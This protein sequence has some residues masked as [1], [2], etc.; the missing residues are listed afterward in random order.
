MLEPEG[1]SV[2]V[3][4]ADRHVFV[5]VP[6]RNPAYHV[7][8]DRTGEE[9]AVSPSDFDGVVEAF[10]Q[11]LDAF[12]KGD[13]RPVTELFSQR[14]DV[15][16][17]NP[18]GPPRLGRAEVEKATEEAAAN[19]TGGSIYFEEVSRYSTPELG[20]I[21]QLE[22][23]EAQLAGSEDRAPVSLRV[24]MIF[25]RE[26]ATWKVAHRHADPITTPRPISTIIET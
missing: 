10:R 7:R 21:V 3:R 20:Y 18:L 23:V 26:G 2:P 12:L 13:A 16:L 6:S 5:C 22:R 14:D 17:A 11:A 15:T 8:P 25:R 4:S 9:A 24:T 1:A 19:F